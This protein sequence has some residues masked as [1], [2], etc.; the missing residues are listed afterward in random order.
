MGDIIIPEVLLVVLP[1][2]IGQRFHLAKNYWIYF[3]KRLVR[4]GKLSIPIYCFG[5]CLML[6]L[7]QFSPGFSC[8]GEF[9]A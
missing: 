1:C 6:M 8:R 3:G 2:D 7:F 5:S 4:E 9:F